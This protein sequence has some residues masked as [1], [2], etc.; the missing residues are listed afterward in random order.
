M[1]TQLLA[2]S[3]TAALAFAAAGPADAA[4][5]PQITDATGDARPT[6]GS[7]A[8]VVSALFSTAGTTAKLGKKTVYT[9]NKLVV[10]VTYA[11]AVPSGANV[12]QVVQFD[13]PGCTDVYLESFDTGIWGSADCLEDDFAFTVKKSG[14]TVTFTLPFKVLGTKHLKRGATLTSLRTYTAH[15]DPVFGYETVEIG[16]GLGAAGL[17]DAVTTATYK[18][19]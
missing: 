5:K 2:A 19:A 9:P 4:P 10:T 14:K 6:G 3:L 7:G 18:I 13:A 8:D 12:A 16:G 17:D 11:G 15:A 1:R